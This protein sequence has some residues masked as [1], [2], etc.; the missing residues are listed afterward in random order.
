M[1]LL[2]LEVWRPKPQCFSA[3]LRPGRGIIGGSPPAVVPQ[4]RPVPRAFGRQKTSRPWD[5]RLRH[6]NARRRLLA[7]DQF[8]STF[9]AGSAACS[10]LL[11]TPQGRVR[12]NSGSG[13]IIKERAIC[14]L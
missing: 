6:E 13:V 1:A 7:F 4:K 8:S 10:L 11:E 5:A 2:S 9:R 14:R 3:W 12:L